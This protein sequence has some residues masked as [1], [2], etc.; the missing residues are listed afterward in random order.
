MQ[1]NPS[2]TEIAQ[3]KAFAGAAHEACAADA[4]QIMGGAGI[5]R[6][7]KIE[8]TFR[9]SKILSIGGGSSGVMKDLA[10]RQMKY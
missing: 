8:R 6:G 1:G 3:L 2:I 5:I 4:V 10:A 7:S 9:E